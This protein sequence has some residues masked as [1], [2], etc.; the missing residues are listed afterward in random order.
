MRQAEDVSG[1]IEV[2]AHFQRAVIDG[3]V[4]PPGP[5][6]KQRDAGDV[7]EII[8]MNVISVDVV[9]GLQH[10]I[11]AFE[12]R[13][14]QTVGGINAGCAQNADR[15]AVALTEATQTTLGV[16]ASQGTGSRWRHTPGLVN[17]G[18]ATITVNPCCTYVYQALW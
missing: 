10:W 15:N 3:I 12:P 2:F 5:A 11:T 9:L 18:T 14:R 8:G 13:S 6:T 17:E 16:N 1:E 7:R 4:N